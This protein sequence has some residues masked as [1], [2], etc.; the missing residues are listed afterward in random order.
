MQ[1]NTSSKKC[2]GDEGVNI[3]SKLNFLLNMLTGSAR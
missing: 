2:V 1:K 3:L